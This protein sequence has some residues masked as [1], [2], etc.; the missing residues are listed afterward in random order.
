MR[1]GMQGQNFA[2]VMEN[3]GPLSKVRIRMTPRKVSNVHAHELAD[4]YVD[5]LQA[6]GPGALTLAGFHLEHEIWTPAGTTLHLPPG[7]P[8]VAVYPEQIT[9]TTGDLVAMETRCNPVADA[10]IIALAG[11]G[12]LLVKRLT[13][14]DLMHRVDP[15][16]EMLEAM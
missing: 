2:V 13:Q 5:V 11:Y 8:H 14:L 1:A 15:S 9:G 6:D 12:E 10:D 3:S 7:M 16:P 4:V